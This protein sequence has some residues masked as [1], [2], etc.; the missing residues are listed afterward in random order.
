M[1]PQVYENRGL[2]FRA[3]RVIILGLGLQR[4]S[5]GIAEQ[6][7]VDGEPA[8]LECPD[9]SGETGYGQPAIIS[10]RTGV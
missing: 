6:R 5:D 10:Y 2:Q 3:N 9:V 1:L 7:A 8:N 4:S